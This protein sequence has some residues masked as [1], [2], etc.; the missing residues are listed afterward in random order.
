MGRGDVGGM[1]V[2]RLEKCGWGVFIRA[3]S[4]KCQ[5]IRVKCRVAYL[6]RFPMFWGSK[7]CLSVFARSGVEEGGTGAGAGDMWPVPGPPPKGGI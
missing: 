4:K 5:P 7:R 3:E 2:G 1:E 6:H